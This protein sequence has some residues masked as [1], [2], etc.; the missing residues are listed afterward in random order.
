MALWTYGVVT[1]ATRNQ[2]FA[3]NPNEV[4]HI[5]G[6]ET[7]EVHRFIKFGRGRPTIRGVRSDDGRQDSE[8]GL[9]D[10][11]ACMEIAEEILRI[12]FNTGQEPLPPMVENL[13][14]LIKQLGGAA[15]AVGL[16]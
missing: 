6:L 3:N 12:N 9:S 8:A 11:R 4:V 2:A 1:R 7:T 13:C 14:H 10:P 5:D 15:W 16:G